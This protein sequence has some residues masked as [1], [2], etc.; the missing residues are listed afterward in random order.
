MII[1]AP[2]EK[3]RLSV[4]S[5]STLREIK[6]LRELNHDNVVRLTDVVIDVKNRDV[7]LVMDYAAWTLDNVTKHHFLKKEKISDFTCQAMMYQC[8]LGLEYLHKNWVL[9]RD[10][11]PQNILIIG[12]GEMSGT[13]QLA[14]LGLARFFQA[15]IKPFDKVD[16]TVVTLWYRAPEL[17][18]GQAHYT[19]AVDIWSLGCIFAELLFAHL[20][21]R[22]ALFPGDPSQNTNKNTFEK[23]QSFRVFS[24]L[25]KPTEKNWPNVDKLPNYK[26]MLL[27]DTGDKKLPQ[28]SEL[29]KKMR[30]M[31]KE[32]LSRAASLNLLE[33]MLQLDPS[34]RISA[35]DALKHTFFKSDLKNKYRNAL[36]DPTDPN[37]QYMN[38]TR[39]AP[40][41]LEEEVRLQQNKVQQ[42]AH[43]YSGS[44][45]K[46]RRL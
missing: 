25:G 41:P 17:L 44:N 39:T 3:E 38:Y 33:K 11:K 13:L 26:S 31:C 27:L 22:P 42:G 29:T 18:L 9:H 40:Q 21:Q 2:N 6:I 28:K 35:S 14:D 15:P 30:A 45:I 46:R 32:D 24:V 8:L 5:I 19:T 20:Y 1:Q 4:T 43:Q 36:I 7:A 16:R 34:K 23:D 37:K 10:L 12:D